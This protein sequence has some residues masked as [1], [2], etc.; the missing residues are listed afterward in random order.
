MTRV[1]L[2]HQMLPEG[3]D[4]ALAYY[5]A[6]YTQG[7]AAAERSGEQQMDDLAARYVRMIHLGEEIERTLAPLTS[8]KCAPYDELADRRGQPERAA[9]QRAIL[10]D[11][12]IA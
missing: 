4:I 10:K 3:R 2:L 8:G 7:L 11:R 6:G 1:P 5:E 9:R 12:G